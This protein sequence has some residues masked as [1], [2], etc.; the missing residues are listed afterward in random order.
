MWALHSIY[1]L[2]IKL[3]NSYRYFTFCLIV[4]KI[5]CISSEMCMVRAIFFHK[6]SDFESNFVSIFYEWELFIKIVMSCWDD[7]EDYSSTKVSLTFEKSVFIC[8]R[9]AENMT[10]ST[11]PEVMHRKISRPVAQ[12]LNQYYQKSILS[13]WY[14]LQT[15]SKIF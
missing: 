5:M 6:K 11:W 3:Y 4:M 14:L 12:D 15:T 2:L 7:S 1:L 10:G 13:F 8:I 9:I